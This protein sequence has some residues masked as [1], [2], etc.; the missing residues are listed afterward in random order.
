MITFKPESHTYWDENGNEYTSVTTLLSKEFPF[1]KEAIAEK[2]SGISSSRYHGMSKE[3]ILRMW[4]DS[5]EHGNDV[6]EAVENYI[7]EKK[8]PSNPHIKPLVEQ[9]S[10]LKFK[11]DLLSEI[12][13]WDE[14][15]KLAGT[16]DILECFDDCIYLFDIKTSNRIND[17]KLMKF[18]LQLELY[19]RM[20]EKRF[21]KPTKTTGIIWFEDYVM[22][23]S[24]TKMRILQ[25]LHLSS[26]VDELLAKRLKEINN[27]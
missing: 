25:P 3:R 17:D 24:K 19:R 2:V 5:S 9:F 21:N 11:G 4:N 7:K 14:K 1:D 6:H 16:A 8:M 26:I 10:K 15:Y 27:G 18:S 20:I 22:K 23:R 12:L 13:V